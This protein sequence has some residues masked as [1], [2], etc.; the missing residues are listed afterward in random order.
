MSKKPLVIDETLESGLYLVSTPIGN[1][2][3][4]TLRALDTLR[5]VS[6]IVCED[7][8]VTKILLRHYAIDKPLT[9]YHDQSHER[10]RT[11]L[12]ERLGQGETLALVSDSGTPLIS[13]PGYKLVRE[14]LSEGI[15]VH[16]VPGV[17]AALAGLCL[18]GLPTDRF[19]FVG[20]L[21]TKGR[22]A[23][24]ADLKN[25][26]CTLI[27]YESIQRISELLQELRAVMGERE[28]VLARELTKLY[29]EVRRGRIEDLAQESQVFSVFKGEVV[30]IIGPESRSTDLE[31][32]DRELDTLFAQGKS[33]RQAVS[34]VSGKYS[35]SV[36]Y[37]RALGRQAYRRGRRGEQLASWFLRIKGYQII[38]TNL[39]T[40]YGEID[41]IVKRGSI[42]AVVEVKV[43]SDPAAAGEALL[44]RQRRRLIQ[45]ANFFL[46]RRPEFNT[47]AIRFDAILFRP[48]RWP[49]HL[50]NAFDDSPY[51]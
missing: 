31:E 10:V 20:F 29:E 3:D 27:V 13:D 21:P 16:V 26:P 49:E 48:W 5:A 30:A 2:K 38:A 28:I 37:R 18:S 23:A 12:L 46:R 15:K 44:S 45:A 1:L 33:V 19:L 42:L 24:I 14:C 50:Q 22:A 4:I 51:N 6:G 41:L 32:I 7:T 25:Y 35:K 39:A 17:S 8:R 36:A 9:V 47:Y 34:E 11:R 40:P 43:R